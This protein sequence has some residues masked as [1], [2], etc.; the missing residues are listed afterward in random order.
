MAVENIRRT[1]TGLPCIA[2]LFGDVIE[3]R[4]KA[5]TPDSFLLHMLET[6]HK[7]LVWWE[8]RAC[9]YLTI[10]D[11]PEIAITSLKSDLLGHARS[12]NIVTFDGRLKDALAEVCTVVELSAR[13]GTDLR[14]IPPPPGPGK[15][16]PDFEC[17]IKSDTGQLQP[18][19]VEVKNCRAPV[20]VV[21]FIQALYDER[22]KTAPDILKRSI[23]LSH[24][25]D[26]TV[27]EDQE[28]TLREVFDHLSKCSLPFESAVTIKDEGMPVEI[29]VR[30][31]EGSGISLTRG[32]GGDTPWGPFTKREKFLSHALAKI[33]K[34]AEQL[35]ARPD[36]KSLLALNMESPDGTVES[37]LLLELRQAVAAE[38]AGQIEIVFLLFYQWLE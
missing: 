5:P 31:R 36:R 32:I 37:D 28:C 8:S 2:K 9:K 21:D 18:Y 3:A 38:F 34:G 13:G 12:S 26:N 29:R 7:A 11:S 15:K 17:L 24:R 16:A 27:T 10:V 19:C 1:L 23:E 35:K 25:W 22:A 20:G 14:R 4:L 30:V 6:R 33:R